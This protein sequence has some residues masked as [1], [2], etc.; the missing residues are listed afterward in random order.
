M[1]NRPLILSPAGSYDA[2]CAA[3]DAGADEIYFGLS[4][5]NARQNAKNFTPEETAL[6]IKRCKLR[7]VKT[8]IT[9]NTLVTDREI[10]DVVSKAYDALCLGADAFIVQDL[11]LASVLKKAIPEI[12][13]HASTQCAC[14]SADGAKILADMGF[15]RV[16]LARELN[17][18]EIKSITSLGIE[19]EMFVHGALCVSH[20]GM[21]LMSSVIGKRSG[22][23][24]LCAQPCRLAYNFGT[25][26]A[27]SSS[28]YPL[29]L[30]DLSLCMHVPEIAE[31]GIT[32][33][34]IEG[35]MKAPQYVSGVTEIWK[36]LVTENRNATH[37]E[38]DYLEKLF[39]RS[40]FTDGYYT[41]AYRE[42]NKKMYGVRTDSDKLDT[43]QLEET[44]E[45]LQ[46]KRGIEIDC[47]VEENKAPVITIKAG[48]TECTV[49]ADFETQTAKGTPLTKEEL[50]KS[51]VKLGDT[52]FVCKG[53][54]TE[55][56]GNVFLAKSQINNLRRTA[57]KELEDKLLYTR[58][59]SALNTDALYLEKQKQT[60]SE[61]K[62]RL[63]P[64]SFYGLQKMLDKYEKQEPESV[65]V[66]L[67]NFIQQDSSPLVSLIKEKN[68][69]FGVR[70]PRVVFSSERE[71]VIS[72]L[73]NAKLCGALYAVAENIG[74]VSVIKESGLELYT[75]YAMNVFNSYTTALLE[76]L[77]AKSVTLSPELITAQMRDIVKGSNK[78]AVVADGR[79]E[80]M[81]LESCVMRAS[82]G[83]MNKADSDI[84]YTLCD[85]T[86]AVFPVKCE[87]R[88]GDK[89][90]PC[91]NIILNSVPVNLHSKPEKLAET[92]AKIYCITET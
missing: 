62:Y 56:K 23:R 11:G 45:S 3:L 25:E 83:C 20:S 21:C 76:N 52:E 19:T 37:E 6:A 42:N 34:K 49:V 72:A 32:S 75:G 22:N 71:G 61:P 67:S 51:L 13:L 18:N 41:G 14:H 44:E 43:K 88:F 50:E 58:N 80:L 17:I 92:G 91:R 86:G 55:I 9:L 60:S 74:H 90:Y 12:V 84:C 15:E 10:P 47:F 2:L 1:N 27:N 53:I 64:N 40:G 79:L 7:G 54:H 68:L 16:V 35:R 65:C 30:K 59:I 87:H 24:G 81:V 70:L 89:Q 82:S 38:Y 26:K 36:K 48:E 63:F 5:H 4:S 29:S 85:R 78:T 77:G 66:P 8:N 33:L 57:V 31:L 46:N 39:S 69:T 28:R 73:N